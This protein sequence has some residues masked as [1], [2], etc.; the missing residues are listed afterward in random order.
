[1]PKLIF[2]SFA[3]DQRTVE[4]KDGVSVMR[5]ALDNGIPD[6]VG[7]CGG[8][9]SC[10]TCHVLVDTT[11][12]ERIPP[13]SAAEDEMLDGTACDRES[14]S[15]LSCQIKMTEQLDNLQVTTPEFQD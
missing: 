2:T 6:I 12:L 15:R 9:L 10:A 4:A 14:N 7:E 13:M 1:M 11:D 8:V 5:A 3:G